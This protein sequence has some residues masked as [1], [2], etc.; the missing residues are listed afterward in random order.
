MRNLKLTTLSAGAFALAAWL[1][2]LGLV[3]CAQQATTPMANSPSSN[4]PPAGPPPVTMS[5]SFCED[6]GSACSPSSSFSLNALR[7]LNVVV[8]W[9]N[10]PE[11]MHLQTLNMLLP[12]GGIYET[13]E[14]TFEVTDSTGDTITVA[15]PVR[16]V[17]TWARQR[18][19]VGNWQ[20][21]VSL[22]GELMGTQ[23]VQLSR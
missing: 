4:L 18:N 11:G 2:A 6:R 23:E 7:D 10:L 3:G 12:D 14:T 20:A 21:Q 19:V 17:G 22:D 16:I 1:S 5:V 9:Q 8:Q 13:F 15:K